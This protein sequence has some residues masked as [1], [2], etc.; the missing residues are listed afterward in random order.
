VD[1]K[2]ELESWLIEAANM[3][4]V[5]LCIRSLMTYLLLATGDI[6]GTAQSVQ[7]FALCPTSVTAMCSCTLLGM[8]L[9][10]TTVGL[11]CMC[12]HMEL[13]THS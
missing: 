2:E 9:L 7:L 12:Y 11:V 6:C 1:E 8:L 3:L 5:R 4:C 13:K 10:M